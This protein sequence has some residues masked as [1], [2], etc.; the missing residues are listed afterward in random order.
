MPDFEVYL[1][2]DSFERDALV[3]PARRRPAIRPRARLEQLNRCDISTT[4]V[5]TLKKGLNDARARPASIDFALAQK[6]IRGVTFQPVQAA[7]RLENFDP[8][9]DRLTLTEVRRRILEQT[10]VFRPED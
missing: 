5:V 8:S 6:C 7:G 10:S 9:T 3:C 2:F 4:L 1:Q